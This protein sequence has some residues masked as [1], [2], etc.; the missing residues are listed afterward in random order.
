[1][2]I[3]YSKDADVLY[4]SFTP[5]TGRIASVENANG[6]ILRID[7]SS[8]TIIGVSIQLFMYRINAGEKIEVPEIG[9]SIPA[10]MGTGIVDSPHFKA[11]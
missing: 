11:N 7:T 8:G 9:F 4:L 2:R 5:P 3:T 10:P 1:V 6:D